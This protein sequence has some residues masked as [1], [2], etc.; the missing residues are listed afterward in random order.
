[1][2]IDATAIEP[3]SAPPAEFP[4][5]GAPG[6]RGASRFQRMRRAPVS[7][8]L[9]VGWFALLAILA[10]TADFL[11]IER[12]DALAGDPNVGPALRWPEFLGFD[13]FG[14]SELTR[15]IYGARESLLVGFL[16][17]AIAMAV[18]TTIGMIAGFRGGWA[19]RIITVFID[20]ALAFPALIL[21]IALAVVL[22]PS[23]S[24]LVIELGIL[25]TPTFA[26]LTRGTTL[27]IANREFVV[28]ARAMG[29]TNR[30]VIVRELFPNVAL[31]L[32]S[33]LF[34]VCS[35]AIVA[36]G[37]LSFLG[38]GIP[39]PAPSWGGMISTGRPFFSEAPHE[40]WLPSI[41]LILTVVSL[42]VIGEWVRRK[43][44]VRESVL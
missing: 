39:P 12:T 1:M 27:S 17:V 37:S 6:D 11:P 25:L 40:V 22:T 29:A 23:V 8:W 14:R 3:L 43:I 28:A 4:P 21:L 19:D 24:T 16:A 44:E 2:A 7:V 15:I 42:N 30:R 33:Y 20:A 32:S 35:V 5:S 36:E 41:A 38:L 31:M 34:I 9:A 13:N 26:R 18:G 10:I